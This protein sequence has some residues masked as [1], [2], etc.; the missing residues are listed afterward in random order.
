MNFFGFFKFFSNGIFKNWSKIYD[1][2]LF[3]S[4]NIIFAYILLLSKLILKK[5]YYFNII[6]TMFFCH[7]HIHQAKITNSQICKSLHWYYIILLFFLW[8]CSWVFVKYLNI[9]TNSKSTFILTRKYFVESLK[10]IMNS[11]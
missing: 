10:K 7:K 11:L 4:I 1:W 2:V 5:K 9:L 3:I 6:N 8:L